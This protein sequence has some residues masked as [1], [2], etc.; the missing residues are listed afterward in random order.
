MCMHPLNKERNLQALLELRASLQARDACA[1]TLN[2]PNALD[3][4][5]LSLPG[6][7]PTYAQEHI[8]HELDRP[9]IE[10]EFT[11]GNNIFQDQFELPHVNI[12]EPTSDGSEDSSDAPAPQFDPL[13]DQ[14]FAGNPP[15]APSPPPELEYDSDDSESNYEF[16]HAYDDPP[17]LR[18][19]YLNALAD[20]IVR[21]NTVRDTETNLKNTLT[22]FELA[23]GLIPEHIVPLTT[24]KSIRQHIGLNTSQL[25]KQVPVCDKCYKRYSMAD[26]SASSLPAVCTRELPPCTGSYM[27]IT[28]KN[29]KPKKIP[30]KV[31]LYMRIIPSLRHMLLR[32]SF[33]QLLREGA[34]SKQQERPP[35][36]YFD[37]SD[38]EVWNSARI[39]LWRVFQQDGTVTDEPIAPGSDVLVSSLGYGLFATLNID[40]FGLSKKHS[41]GAIY[42]AI[43][44]LPRH[45]RYQI[46]NI[47]LACVVSG[48]TEPHLE[49]INFVLEP[50]VESFKQ[51][52]AGVAVKVYQE[53]LPQTVERLYAYPAMVDADVPAQAKHNQLPPHSHNKRIGCDCEVTKADLNNPNGKAYDPSKF[54]YSD[55]WDILRL[56]KE[57][58]TNQEARKRIAKDYGIRWSVFNELPGWMPHSSAP[59]NPMHC[60]YLG[61]V[62][63]LWIDVIEDGYLLNSRQEETFE[64]FLSSLV[65][66]SQIGR[67]PVSKSPTTSAL[68]RRKADEW[69]R[70]ISVLPIAL[71]ISWRNALDQISDAAPNVPPQT[72]KKPSFT[73]NLKAVW[74]CVQQLSAS[75]RLFTSWVAYMPDIERA[76]QYMRHYC[77]GLLRLMVKLQ[78]NHHFAMH[79]KQYFKLFGPCYAWW[80]FPYERFNG[81]L[82]QIE[83]NNHPDELETT[84]AR[85]WIRTHQLHNYLERL[86]LDATPQERA[87]LEKLYQGH[88]DRGTLLTMAESLH[89]GRPVIQPSAIPSTFINLRNLDETGDIY[90]AVLGFACNRWPHRDFISDIAFGMPGK[91]FCLH[92]TARKLHFIHRN[93]VR[94][95]CESSQ[96]SQSDQYALLMANEGRCPVKILWHFQIEVLDE[97]PEICSV[98]SRLNME[99]IPLLPWSLYAKDLGYF[100]AWDN[101]FG[102]V[103]AIS[104]NQLVSPVVTAPFSMRHSAAHLWIVIAYDR[105]GSKVFKNKDNDN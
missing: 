26:V 31:L 51:L 53:N 99:D 23:P 105:T 101:S 78:P 97:E 29:G 4:D 63:R 95:G 54:I 15:Q 44:N 57:S 20:H 86:P 17:I 37:V 71:W 65:W 72:A 25:L 3:Q 46:H 59:F 93:T 38:G 100:V 24:L 58:K 98:V 10:D 42:L 70:L 80:L 14:G 7:G 1:N 28:I 48:P 67:L 87:V 96:R 50:I 11:G 104:P 55:E 5:Q 16:T 39:G 61:I 66:P 9:R 6:P 52:Y 56:S 33:V 2:G 36:T 69:Q 64:S 79:F 91:F 103:E 27:K 40:W 30:S 85:W 35:N 83:L 21:K 84:L 62:N 12:P 45:A 89:G 60:L 19:T 102:P 8:N 18:Y 75:V 76:E 32:P 94:Y 47:I 81:I 13:I 92:K 74:E 22:A 88:Q 68:N 90:L 41:C 82:E 43:L 77:E 73:R 49:D 34:E